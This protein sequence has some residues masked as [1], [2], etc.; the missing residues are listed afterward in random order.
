MV[1]VL[2]AVLICFEPMHHRSSERFNLG[3]EAG[4]LHFG[5]VAWP[6]KIVNIS[7]AG[8]RLQLQ[9]TSLVDLNR[10]LRLDFKLRNQHRIGCSAVYIADKNEIAVRFDPLEKSV[11]QALI[12]DMYANEVLQRRQFPRFQFRPVMRQ[13]GRLMKGS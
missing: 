13:L 4:V 12:R 10:H 3:G 6:V 9:D 2:I 8:A 5:E 11:R 7:F 1:I